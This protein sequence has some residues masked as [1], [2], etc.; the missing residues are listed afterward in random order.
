MWQMTASKQV[1]RPENSQTYPTLA[2]AKS[3]LEKPAE[4]NASICIDP[5]EVLGYLTR[6]LNGANFAAKTLGPFGVEG[7]VAVSGVFVQAAVV[8]ASGEQSHA[9]RKG[10]EAKGG[11]K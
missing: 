2:E 3:L 6:E 4:A 11:E 10:H 7:L 5:N 9:D 8:E 1:S